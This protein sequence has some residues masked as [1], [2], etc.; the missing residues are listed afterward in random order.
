MLTLVCSQ[1]WR[2]WFRRCHLTTFTTLRRWQR[3]TAWAFAHIC[4]VARTGLLRASCLLSEPLRERGDYVL[5]LD[6][7]SR[8]SSHA[9][10][11]VT[12]NSDA[13]CTQ[14]MSL[15]VLLALPVWLMVLALAVL[16][17]QTG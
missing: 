15:R 11:H 9:T 5:K 4:D 17:E 2:H 6:V 14:R 3:T 12:Y 7:G 8:F 10:A 1:R 13:D 16:D